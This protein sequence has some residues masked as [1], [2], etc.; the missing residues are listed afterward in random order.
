M[1]I[2]FI[3]CMGF[4]MSIG[5]FYA[6]KTTSMAASTSQAAYVIEIPA[7][8]SIENILPADE[9]QAGL[10]RRSGSNK[11][12]VGKGYPKNGDPLRSIQE[13]VTKFNGKAP[14]VSF[15]AHSGFGLNDPT[16]AIGPN[17]YV[18]AFNSGF[19]IRDRNGNVLLA[20][21]SLSVL[22]PGE[23]LGDPVVVYDRYAD[24]FI[25]MEFSNSPNGFLIAICQG[26]DPVNDG[27][28]TYRFNT[29]TFPD[30]EKLS[31]WSDGY[32]ITA[33]KD[34]GSA[35]TSEVVW[36]LERDEMLL[37]NP[38][39]QIVG[40]GLTGITTSGFYSPAGFNVNGPDLPPPGDAPIVYLQD[41][42][43]SGVTDDHVKLW[44]INVDWVNAANSTI[45]AP[46]IITTADFDSVFDN[47]SFSNLTQPSG[48]DIDAL[49]ATVMYMAQYRRF[50]TY[51]SAVFNFVVDLTNA[52]ALAGI[53]WY[54]LRQA[55]DGDAWTIHQEGTYVQPDGLSAF[56]GGIAMD[57][58]GNIGLAYTVVSNVQAPSIRYTGRLSADPLNTMTQVED[59]IVNSTFSD[60]TTR[61][62]DY[63]QM[64]VDPLDDQTF[65]HIAEYFGSGSS[66]KSIVGAFKLAADFALDAGVVSIDAPTTATLTATESI[67]VTIRNF[68]L[69]DISNVPVS[70]QIDGGAVIA[71]NFAGTIASGADVQYTFPTTADLSILG[72][73]YNISATTS[74]VGDEFADNDGV[75]IN[76]THVAPVDLG[77][78]AI[79]NPSTG[80]NLLSNEVVTVTIEN[81]GGQAQTNFPVSYTIN[82]GTA[83][84]GTVPGP[85]NAGETLDFTF[86]VTGDFSA[87]GDYIISASTSIAG[88][89]DNGNNTTQVL[90]TNS[91]CQ[92]AVFNLLTDC[93][94]DTETS[95][96]LEDDQGGLI[97]E[98]LQ[99]TL[100]EDFTYN[101][102]L[103]LSPG[104]YKLILED[105]FGDGLNGGAF[106]CTDGNYS[107]DLNGTTIITMGNPDFDMIIEHDFC[108]EGNSGIIVNLKALLEGAFNS[109]GQLMND[110]LR[111]GNELP[112]GEPYTA[113]GFNQVG[114]GG[115]S[116]TL[117]IL[118]VTGV[119]AI[120]DWI[121]VEL[122]DGTDPTSVIATQVG[123]IQ[124]DGDIV[125]VDGVSPLDLVNPGVS[126]V[127]VVV[128]HRN[129]FGV[130]TNDVYATSGLITI[131]YTDP[132]LNVFGGA[133][134]MT[135]VDG[136]MMLISA[137]ANGDGQVNSVDKNIHWRVENG[138]PFD[139]STIKADFNLDGVIN[140]IDK[141]FFWR[142]NNGK[143]DSLD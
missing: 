26:P 87:L 121:F 81:F 24:R 98:A 99:G 70:Y 108:V 59:V 19:G 138:A 53:R 85:I 73:V 101:Y 29:G 127:Y 97:Q 140:S 109:S 83:V 78:I 66:R 38:S 22:F 14:S 75:N 31:I 90:V 54:E 45:S 63:A 51:N 91:L 17:H 61:Y 67:T 96:R 16:G 30:Y 107:F 39:A 32:Y 58:F 89:S 11:T 42:G 136:L 57:N 102:D 80:S 104:C 71:G 115:E 111:S 142:L 74:L 35:G 132:T 49:Q 134:A 43:W 52:D 62:G 131:D 141:N 12:I 33:N 18:N 130:R 100:A 20:E 13:N 5:S 113:L 40:F 79:T 21:A 44:N 72:N 46:Q 123:L 106:G 125:G 8:S 94:S 95:W 9:H 117:D 10:T 4:I 114:G 112:L 3:L 118:A 48:T 82:G 84:P 6:Q 86:V 2:R 128:R 27:W 36:A 110:V 50:P 64:T 137:D 124:R 1:K 135:S 129:H 126:D 68:G 105:S 25:V 119:D 65:W 37:G 76:V 122:R 41:D 34:Q 92:P 47:G 103:C 69:N 55:N 88:D 139:Y 77:V 93:Y 15:D 120:V 28:F 143:A 60:P 23:T 133:N 7:L 56:C 116:T